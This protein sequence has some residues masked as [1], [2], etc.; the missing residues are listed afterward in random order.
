MQKNNYLCVF[1][2]F[3]W[4]INTLRFEMHKSKRTN[5]KLQSTI[6]I[7]AQNEQN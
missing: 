5:N 2:I 7:A 3:N 4:K 1:Q 6:T